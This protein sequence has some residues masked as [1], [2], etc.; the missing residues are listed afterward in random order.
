MDYAEL[1]ARIKAALSSE[2]DC[3]CDR[4]VRLKERDT[5]RVME[6][7]REHEDRAAAN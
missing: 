6:V 3:G 7:I 2:E 1:T 4:C 5:E